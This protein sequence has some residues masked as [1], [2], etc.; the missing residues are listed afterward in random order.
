MRVLSFGGGKQSTALLVLAAQGRVDFPLMVFA[1]VGDDSEY[2]PTLEYFR[3]VAL[4]YAKA[5]GIEMVEVQRTRKVG[6]RKGEQRTL[7][8]DMMEMEQR[9]VPIPVRLANGAPGNRTC[10][11]EYKI[12]VVSDYLKTRG[13]SPEQP[14]VLG[15]GISLDEY[16]RMRSDDPRYPHIH[17][18]YPLIDLRLTRDVC[19]SI[20]EAAGLPVPPKS[21]CYFCPFK[22]MSEWGALRRNH[23]DLFAKAVELERVVNQRRASIGRDEVYLSAALK[24]LDKVFGDTVQMHFDDLDE[25]LC[26]GDV[27][28][29]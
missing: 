16:W 5:H 6:E 21:A 17:K 29:T 7:Y 24:P 3:Q 26:T 11:E 8:S 10:T 12:K 28:M 23:P 14:A 22:R 25:G 9:R 1:N 15:M 20:I 19:I 18:E 2:P 27:C 13:A 4:P